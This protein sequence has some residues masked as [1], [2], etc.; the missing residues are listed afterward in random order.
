MFSVSGITPQVM[1]PVQ[2]L[3]GALHSLK[4]VADKGVMVTQHKQQCRKHTAWKETQ[5]EHRQINAACKEINAELGLAYLPESWLEQVVPQLYNRIPRDTG[6]STSYVSADTF[7]ENKHGFKASDLYTSQPTSRL[8]PSCIAHQLASMDLCRHSVYYDQRRGF[9]TIRSDHPHK[10]TSTSLAQKDAGL[11]NSMADMFFKKKRASAEVKE[12]I[13]PGMQLAYESHKQDRLERGSYEAGYYDGIGQEDMDRDAKAAYES[14]G[15]QVQDMHYNSFKTGYY[16]G[17]MQAGQ[18]DTKKDAPPKSNSRRVFR[19]I[20]IVLALYFLLPIIIK[21]LVGY[22]LGFK[23]GSD[24]DVVSSTDVTFDDVRGI[25]EAK[26][27]LEEIVNYL[28]EPDKYTKLGGKL[29]KGVL[30]I[31]SPGTGKTLLARAVAGEAGVPFFFASGSDFDH[32]FVGTGAKKIRDMFAEAKL[33]TPCVIFIDELDSIGGKRIES[34][35]HPYARQTIN[36]L[37]AEMDGFKQSEG[38]IVLGAT[39]FPRTLDGA[40]TRPGRFDISVNVPVPD[41]KGR[42]EIL[43]LYLAKVTVAPDVDKE[44]LARGTVGFTGADICNLVNQAALHAAKQNKEAVDMTDM[45]F[46]KDKIIMGPER[47]SIVIDDKN[48][49]IT[50]FHEG[51]HALVA[52]FTKDSKPINKATIMPRGDTLGHVSLLPDK[53]QWNQTKSQL[54]A[55]MDICMGGRVAEEIMFGTDEVTTGAGSDFDQA[56]RIAR[57][58]ITRFGMSDKLG[59]MT[60]GDPDDLTSEG[61]KPSQETQSIIDAEVRKLLEE[62]YERARYI[63]KTHSKEHKRIAEALLKYETLSS[64]EIELVIKGKSIQSKI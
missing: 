57:L 36:Q 21:P 19:I 3:A 5:S 4:T 62:S 46:A 18:T 35:M 55:Q 53:D 40:L 8:F 12:S 1:L 25:A 11:V 44:K 30:L 45:E 33:A 59:V 24:V 20:G 58:M 64:E 49:E 26:A 7:F 37:L 6:W 31:G 17:Y 48:K 51:G 39:N 10:L 27:E 54:L 23:M 13:V 42:I 15:G 60:Y 61:V 32:I 2:H 34:P 9:K 56:T 47:K 50:A 41:V 28:K 38:I 63:L 43:D 29:P 52:F 14:H 22:K 16:D